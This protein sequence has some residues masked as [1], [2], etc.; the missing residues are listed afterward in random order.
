MFV[1]TS[2]LALDISLFPPNI[3]CIPRSGCRC[4]SASAFTSGILTPLTFCTVMERRYCVYSAHIIV[5]L[6]ILC[7]HIH[8]YCCSVW[9]LLEIN[10]I[11]TVIVI[12]NLY[13]FY[14]EEGLQTKIQNEIVPVICRNS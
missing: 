4:F 14:F 13:L 5:T 8:I 2:D 1:S 6:F 12:S 10:K 7:H 3:L 9:V 11:R